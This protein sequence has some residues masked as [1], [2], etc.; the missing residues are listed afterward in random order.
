MKSAASRPARRRIAAGALALTALLGATGCSAVNPVATAIPYS[1]SDGTTVSQPD[2]VEARNLALVGEGASGPARLIG[3]LVNPTDADKSYTVSLQ[4]GGQAT[5]QVPAGQSVR[6]EDEQN[7]QEIERN[8]WPGQNAQGTIAAD[9]ASVEVG[10]PVLS[11]TQ[12][13]YA[14][15]LPAGQQPSTEHLHEETL[16]Y[17]EGH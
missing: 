14:E 3:T 4:D 16:H 10:I 2:L 17:G 13:Q 12:E 8:V 15:Y 7:K 1:P 11:A 9:G 5:V 6:L